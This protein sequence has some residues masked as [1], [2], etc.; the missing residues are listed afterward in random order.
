MRSHLLE[1][2]ALAAAMAAGPAMAQPFPIQPAAPQVL[3]RA[4]AVAVLN[5]QLDP[6]PFGTGQARVTNVGSATLEAGRLIVVTVAQAGGG[7]GSYP[8]RAPL[9][10]G[11]SAS[12]PVSGV[13]LLA[14]GCVANA[15]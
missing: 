2:L 8:L 6:R 9:P 15:Q 3:P 14:R 13:S 4:P 1:A 12:V 10:P 11:G 5:C 7:M